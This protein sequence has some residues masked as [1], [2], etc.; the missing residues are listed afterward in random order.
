MLFSFTNCGGY[1][2]GQKNLAIK[3]EK[4][5]SQE[6]YKEA[7]ISYKELSETIKNSTIFQ[8]IAEI[9]LKN[10]N[11]GKSIYNYKL[12]N[13]YEQNCCN[14]ELEE[15]RSKLKQ[16]PLLLD[17]SY[18]INK[19][20]SSILLL[21]SALTLSALL[22]GKNLIKLKYYHLGMILTSVLVIY[23]LLANFCSVTSLYKIEKCVI[24]GGDNN[25]K[26]ESIVIKDNTIAY[27]LADKNSQ[28]IKSLEDGIEL[29]VLKKEESWSL[30]NLGKNRSGWIENNNLIIEK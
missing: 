30:V 23:L 9:Q 29:L 14:S 1:T 16:K 15:I 6:K 19:N 2:E 21:I 7:L 10:N 11:I 8:K 18:E 12:A 28:A 22:V 5:Y 20:I 3:A 13:K 24:G 27:S 17:K 4:L 26:Y 25:N